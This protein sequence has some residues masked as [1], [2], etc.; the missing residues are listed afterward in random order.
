MISI[1][2]IDAKGLRI[3]LRL[4]VDYRIILLIGISTTIQHIE[5]V[6]MKNITY[7]IDQE[8]GLVISRVGSELAWPVLDYDDMRQENNYIMNYTLAKICVSEV[9]SRWGIL[10]WTKKISVEIKN[11]HRRFWGFKELKK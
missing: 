11:P 8:T 6:K 7:A 5:V 4:F 3:V 10:K 1:G 9:A 2:K